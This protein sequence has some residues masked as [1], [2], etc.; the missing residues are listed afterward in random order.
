MQSPL[1]FGNGQPLHLPHRTLARSYIAST[2]LEMQPSVTFR[3]GRPLLHGVA[4]KLAPFRLNYDT[5]VILLLFFRSDEPVF[6]LPFRT[7]P[8][9]LVGLQQ[10]GLGLSQRDNI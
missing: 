9:E 5:S 8:Q 1:T 7:R 6:A 4:R 2:E 10:G 3:N